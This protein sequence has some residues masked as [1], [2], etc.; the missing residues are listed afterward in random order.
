MQLSVGEAAVVLDLTE[1]R[2][3]QL[4]DAGELPATK[5]GGRWVLANTDVEAFARQQRPAGRPLSP[6]TAWALLALAAGRD[7]PPKTYSQMSRLRARLRKR[8]HLEEVA[9]DVRRRHRPDLLYAHPG[10]LN[11]LR[12]DPRVVLTGVSAPGH[13]VV[14]PQFV[15]G[16]VA[17]RHHAE[18]CAK[19]RLQPVD[20]A[21]GNVRLLV[22]DT[23]WWPFP[24][25]RHAWPAV[26]AVDLFDSGEPRSVRAARNLWDRVRAGRRWEPVR[27]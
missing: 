18:L 1:N 17:P 13:D 11:R 7:A 22:P 25:A 20:G 27:G 21:A 2:V 3:R 6:D 4:I 15:E 19:Y 14:A 26:V 24:G 10:V 23:D 9:V 12:D 5:V 8:P 16:Y